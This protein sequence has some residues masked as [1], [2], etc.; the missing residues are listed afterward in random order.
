VE[1][2][3][4]TDARLDRSIDELKRELASSDE[5]ESRA[6]R[7]VERMAVVLQSS[8]LFRHGDAAVAELFASSRLAD[9]WGT[10]GTLR[11]Q[12]D[13]KSVIERHRPRF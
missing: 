12:R 4:G 9:G 7:V 1:Q 6:R 2:A 5:P 13:L 8:L 11:T 10:F 3:R